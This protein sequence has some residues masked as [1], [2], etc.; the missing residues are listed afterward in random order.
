MALEQ[1]EELLNA[2]LD[3][4]VD[5]ALEAQKSAEELVTNYNMSVAGRD[6]ELEKVGTWLRMQADQV[7][8]LTLTDSLTLPTF[9][10]ISLYTLMIPDPQHS[11]LNRQPL[12]LNQA[13]YDEKALSRRSR[14]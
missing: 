13:K 8:T 5:A 7:M 14:L 2:D 11:T 6:E 4:D 9:S 10:I 1:S 12:A 3:A